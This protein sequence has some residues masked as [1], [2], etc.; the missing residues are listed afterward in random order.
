[1]QADVLKAVAH[2]VRLQ[3]LDLLRDGER[4]VCDVAEALGTGRSNA[5]RHLAVL[6]KAGLAERRKEGLKA[7]YRLRTSRALRFTECVMAVLRERISRESRALG[8][9]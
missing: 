9:E 8:R 2:P 1:M 5:S 6:L 4:C 7:F 3:V